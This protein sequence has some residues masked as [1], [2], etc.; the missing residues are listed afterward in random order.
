MNRTADASCVWR[1]S[2]DAAGGTPIQTSS[3]GPAF[4]GAGEVRHY[5]AMATTADASRAP[6]LDAAR[7]SNSR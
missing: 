4:L 5:F 2:A 7:N 3:Q 1:D 6:T